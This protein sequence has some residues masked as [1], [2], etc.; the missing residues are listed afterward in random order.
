VAIEREEL[1]RKGSDED[2]EPPPKKFRVGEEGS[3]R[4]EGEHMYV[5]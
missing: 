4:N 1:K 5:F 3:M 2:D